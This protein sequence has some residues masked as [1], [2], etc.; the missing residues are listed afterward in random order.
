MGN[1]AGLLSVC[2]KI[3]LLISASRS[4]E[5]VETI[6]H[7]KTVLKS[8]N[9][10]EKYP[11]NQHK[12]WI[13]NQTTGRWAMTIKDFRLE[14]SGQCVK[15]Y[16]LIRRSRSTYTTP[17]KLCGYSG[18]HSYFSEGSYLHITF[19]SDGSEE[20]KGFSIEVQHFMNLDEAKAV[21]NKENKQVKEVKVVTHFEYE[22]LFIGLLCVLSL[23]A[24]LFFS[25]FGLFIFGML[26]RRHE[27]VI[28]RDMIARLQSQVVNPPLERRYSRKGSTKE[29]NRP[30]FLRSL[31]NQSTTALL[32]YQSAG[33]PQTA[34]HV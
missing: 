28:Q 29:H 3:L 5:N 12:E 31:S 6:T 14:E 18:S 15:D 27:R 16:L 22:E 1:K 19:H 33:Y 21:V 4:E 25:M 13:F 17:V 26:K 2:A 34:D 11:S 32:S 7:G 30:D 23:A 20:D 8:P 24:V 9:Y 10:P